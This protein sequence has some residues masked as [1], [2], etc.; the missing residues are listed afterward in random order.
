MPGGRFLPQTRI[1][2][3]TFTPSGVSLIPAHPP[4][5]VSH[6]SPSAV[7][8][9]T[10]VCK[11]C[12][13]RVD[14]RVADEPREVR[15]P[16]CHKP[17]PI[18][19]RDQIV[20]PIVHKPLEQPG[21]YKLIPDDTAAVPGGTSDPDRPPARRRPLDE[22]LLVVCGV[23]HARLHPPIRA[24]SY[25]VRCPDCHKPV[26]VPGPEEADRLRQDRKRLEPKLD[27]IESIPLVQPT[28]PA[29]RVQ[30]FFAV[31]GTQIR[32]APVSKPPKWTWF[33]GIWTFPW[34]AEVLKKWLFLS[35]GITLLF[36]LAAVML[37]FLDKI[38]SGE[39]ARVGHL[40]AFF[41]MPALWIFFW[42]AS[43][44]SSVW[45]HVIIDTAAG[46]RRITE[47]PESGWRDGIFAF[48]MI[49]FQFSLTLLLGW[50]VAKAGEYAG[51]P[52]GLCL[53]VAVLLLFPFFVMSMLETNAWYFPF[54]GPVAR[55]VGTRFLDWLVCYLLLCLS[56]G[57]FSYV[58]GFALQMNPPLVLLG[59]GWIWAALILISAR[60]LGRL[61]W[62]ITR[63]PPQESRE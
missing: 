29:P 6:R 22:D 31:Q 37:I 32:R 43:Y 14:E 2:P 39:G 27:P 20:A 11:V 28:G 21:V 26:R 44:G 59:T 7:Q 34:Q 25:K 1:A 33:S 19:G 16:D 56:F 5:P 58:W 30:T 47:W 40:L 48:M 9:V 17:V 18:P 63:L 4:R 52:F 55:S 61:G 23:C 3:R 10:V 53:D 51:A 50:F 36:G 62:K 13:T 60:L 54:S 57:G 38:N 12:G 35:L 15:C 41:A 49:A 42:T 45:L 46:N 24:Q 8:Y